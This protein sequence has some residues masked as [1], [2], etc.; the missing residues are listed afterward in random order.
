MAGIVTVVTSCIVFTT[1]TVGQEST[2][3]TPVQREIERQRQ[4]LGSLEVEERRDALMRLEN[5][6]RPE[7]SRAAAAALND[8]SPTVRAAAAHAVISLPNHEAATLLLPLLKDKGEFVRREIVFALGETRHPSAVSPLVDLLNRDKQRSVRAAAAIALGEIGDAA[9]VPALA[10]IIAGDSSKKQKS[11]SDEEE[12]VV[13]SAVRSLGQIGSRAAV[14]VLIS[15]LQNE[16][17]SIDT[18]REAATALGRIGD[19]SALPALNAAFLANADPYLSEAA[20]LAVRQ[21]NRA[22]GKGAGN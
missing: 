15:A 19:D 12:F 14:P 4:R 11:R 16:S 6:K 22:K 9:A 17:N 5:L 7:A 18:R 1:L 20:R 3:L 8:A 21:I 13:R 10:Q 2:R